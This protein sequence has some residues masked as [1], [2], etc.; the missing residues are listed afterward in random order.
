MGERVSGACV[1][2]CM[3]VSLC[4]SVCVCTHVCKLGVHPG[5]RIFCILTLSVCYYVRLSV[6]DCAFG[7]L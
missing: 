1:H 6:C 4:N 5:V 7:S 2:V 3:H